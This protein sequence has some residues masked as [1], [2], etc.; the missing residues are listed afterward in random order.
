MYEFGAATRFVSEATEGPQQPLTTGHGE[1]SRYG[2]VR[3][4]EAYVFTV[5]ADCVG[6]EAKIHDNG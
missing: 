5:E 3:A 4:H 6:V 1:P 2:I